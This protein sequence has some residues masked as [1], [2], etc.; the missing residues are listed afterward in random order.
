MQESARKDVERVFGV[1]QAIFAIVR[2]PT[3]FW[4]IETLVHHVSM[5]SDA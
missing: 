2:R 4:G 3:H 1:F 5:Y